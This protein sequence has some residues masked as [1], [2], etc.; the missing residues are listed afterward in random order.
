[1]AENEEQE[2]AGQTAAKVASPEARLSLP[3]AMTV[4]PI[5]RVLLAECFSEQPHSVMERGGSRGEHMESFCGAE[6]DLIF[7]LFKDPKPEA[8]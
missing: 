8:L 5:L 4:L 1:M 7:R 3:D 2:K 6:G